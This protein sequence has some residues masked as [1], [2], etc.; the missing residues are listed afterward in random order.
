MR[1]L[2]WGGCNALINYAAKP[3]PMPEWMHL[4]PMK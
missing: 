1:K 3:E 2:A 4:T